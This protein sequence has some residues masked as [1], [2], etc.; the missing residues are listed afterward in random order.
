M[1][2]NAALY[3]LSSMLGKLLLAS[4]AAALLLALSHKS[5]WVAPQAKPNILLFFTDDQNAW[6]AR[7]DLKS[8]PNVDK[9]LRQKGFEAEHFYSPISICCPARSSLL[10]VQAAH[11]HNITD[12]LPPYGGWPLFNA[13]GLNSEWVHLP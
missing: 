6:D 8:M 10:R 9:L 4:A 13:F 7:P 5:P 12:V 11:N 3:S 1:L 2:V